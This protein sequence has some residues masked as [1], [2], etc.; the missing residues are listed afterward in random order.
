MLLRQLRISLLLLL[1]L[2]LLRIPTSP[3][4][5]SKKNIG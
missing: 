1:L 3:R 5:L 2:L 4:S